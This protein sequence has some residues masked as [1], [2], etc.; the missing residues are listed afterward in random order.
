METSMP[1]LRNEEFQ[2]FLIA[3]KLYWVKREDT[4]NPDMQRDIIYTFVDTR[5]PQ[6]K[7]ETTHHQNKKMFTGETLIL[8]HI[9]QWIPVARIEYEGAYQ[10]EQEYEIAAMHTFRNKCL[11]MNNPEISPLHRIFYGRLRYGY[12]YDN[13]F[14]H[15]AC[16]ITCPPNDYQTIIGKEYVIPAHCY[17]SGFLP[18]YAPSFGLRFRFSSSH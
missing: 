5:W 9:E 15:Y 11:R 13:G 4:F 2:N 14:W 6:W 16:I 17:I 18:A 3:F 10:V 7:C 1:L 12:P 8:E